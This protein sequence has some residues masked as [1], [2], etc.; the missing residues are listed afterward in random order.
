MMLDIDYFK[1]VNDNY[2]HQFRDYVLEAVSNILINN[3]NSIGY[4]VRFGGGEYY[5]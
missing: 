1:Q 3:I 4:V 2:G 5:P